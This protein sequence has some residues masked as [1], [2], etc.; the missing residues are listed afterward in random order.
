MLLDKHLVYNETFKPKKK[1][2]IFLLGTPLLG[3]INFDDKAL[4]K[5]N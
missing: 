2:T 1:K 3:Y 5:S 4:A